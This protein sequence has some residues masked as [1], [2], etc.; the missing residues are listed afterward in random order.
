MIL[1]TVNDKIFKV[2]FYIDD[3]YSEIAP[4][5]VDADFFYLD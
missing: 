5:F 4:Q 2:Q 3:H 1:C